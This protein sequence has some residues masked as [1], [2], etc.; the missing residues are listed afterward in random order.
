MGRIVDKK[1]GAK[2]NRRHAI[3]QRNEEIDWKK[4]NILKQIIENDDAKKLNDFCFKLGRYYADEELSTS[5]IR[6]ILYEIL[7][8]KDYDEKKLQLLRPKLA[9]VAGRHERK[10]TEGGRKK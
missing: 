9:Y 1:G 6:K 2:M 4:D 3:L 8:M 10:T 5:Q 7:S